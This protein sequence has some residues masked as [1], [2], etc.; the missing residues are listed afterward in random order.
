MGNHVRLIATRFTDLRS[1]ETNDGFRLYDDFNECSDYMNVVPAD[2]REL[3]AAVVRDH[4]GQNLCDL[5][6]I[7]KERGML[8]GATS[9]TPEEVA[10]I[11]EDATTDIAEELPK[12]LMRK[13]G[14]CGG[15]LCI[16]DSR[17]PVWVLWKL[18]RER[19]D[20][21]DFLLS[22]Y[23]TLDR[24]SMWVSMSY[25][26]DHKEE[27]EADEREHGGEDDP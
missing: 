5:I 2:D 21:E 1:G 17:I 16:A 24:A 23:P 8:C 13:S 14:V 4:S 15:A 19:G 10:D 25:A 12:G 7:A 20:G 18:Y 3:L 27:I 9:F 11:I 26:Y 6:D 22:A